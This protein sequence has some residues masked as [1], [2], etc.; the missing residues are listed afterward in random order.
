MNVDT[1]QTTPSKP[2][3]PTGIELQA[4]PMITIHQ[5]YS[6]SAWKGQMPSKPRRENSKKVKAI[7]EEVLYLDGGRNAIYSQ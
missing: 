6:T 1:S 7:G 3:Q 5:K 2:L 4:A